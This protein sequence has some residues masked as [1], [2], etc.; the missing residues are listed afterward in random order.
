MLSVTMAED[1]RADKEKYGEV[2]KQK[3][4]MLTESASAALDKIAKKR[5]T[6]RSETIE[7]LI[8]EE[9]ARSGVKI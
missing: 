8:R 9:A 5:K 4:F 6:T 3:Q 7:Q 2:K 1:L